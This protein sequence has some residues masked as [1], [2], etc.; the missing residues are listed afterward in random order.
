MSSG[1]CGV[2]H[3]VRPLPELEVAVLHLLE[4]AA[5]VTGELEPLALAAHEASVQALASL[6]EARHEEAIEGATDIADRSLQLIDAGQHLVELAFDSIEPVQHGGEPRDRHRHAG[7]ARHGAHRGDE[8]ERL[9][10]RRNLRQLRGGLDDLGHGRQ[11]RGQLE[12]VREPHARG[13][14][15]GEL[16]VV[17]QL[18]RFA[19]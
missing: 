11:V 15:R 6:A 18:M 3:R 19:A 10:R 12:Q 17:A 8:L 14:R 7:H 9:E 1:I 2:S 4:E 13:Q 5:G 16:S